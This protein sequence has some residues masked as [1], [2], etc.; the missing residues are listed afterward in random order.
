MMGA[1]PLPSLAAAEAYVGHH[2][3][4]TATVGLSSSLGAATAESYIGMGGTASEAA[5]V[6]HNTEQTTLAAQAL[7]KGQIMHT[8]AAAHPAAASQMVPAPVAHANRFEEAADE[9]I[10]PIVLGGLTPRIADL[11]L[12]YYGFMWPNNAAAG[13]RYGAT[14]DML[15]SA[16]MAPSMPSISGG[17]I[18]GAAVAAASVAESAAMSGMQAAVGMVSSGA[19]AVAGPA[20]ALPASAMSA[21]SSSGSS[22]ASAPVTSSPPAQ[23]MAAVTHT[24]PPTPAQTMA[25]AQTSPGMYAPSPNANLMTPPPVPPSQ[26]PVQ[27][28]MPRPPITPPMSAAPGVTSFAPPAQPFSP[29][30][31]TSGGQAAGLKPGMLNA[32]A[33]RGP[34]SAMPLVSSGASTG[35]ALATQP[36]AY[37]APQHPLPPA[38]ASPPQPPLLSPGDT[39]QSL[40]PPQPQQAPPPP[41]HN[42]P[43]PPQQQP[44]HPQQQPQP[45]PNAGATP[46]QGVQNLGGDFK[47][48]PAQA[49]SVHN[50]QDVHNIVDPLPPG[51]NPGV[52]ELPTAAEIWG[53]YGTLTQNATPLPT[54]TYGQGAGQWAQLPDGTKIGIRPDSKS[55]GPTVEIWYPDG[56]EVDVHQ[57]LPKKPA[58]QPAPEPA[59]Q[60]QPNTVPATQTPAPETHEPSHDDSG[61]PSFHVDPPSPGVW[62]T[63]V[64]I[65]GVIGG[66]IGGIGEFAR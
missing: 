22:T 39:A 27:P 5:L 51:R 4:I 14:L 65:L 37:V 16:L 46:D 56:E 42:P 7:T 59:P 11:N 40:T 36:L 43:Q 57:P 19:S 53:L 66:I 20:A 25:P 55:G 64:G 33:L 12:E 2:A 50:A 18:A 54:G 23:S 9:L 32:A 26:A 21:V 10:N 44:P 17:S 8:A 61:R 15:G 31:P 6:S 13:V 45:N 3:A 52:K 47:D 58:P 60:P 41:P 38:P 34:V 1:G 29:P 48:T 49:L 30:P 28:M 63:I 35:T 62:T 24:A